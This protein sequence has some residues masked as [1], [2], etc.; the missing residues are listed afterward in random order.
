[1]A[2]ESQ[3]T[4][5]IEE[6]G[7][8]GL[9]QYREGENSVLFDWEFGS[10]SAVVLIWPRDSNEWEEIHPWAS[11]RKL[12]IMTNVGRDVCR[13]KA[14]SCSFEIDATNSSIMIVAK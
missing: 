7:R 2:S 10:D 6:M 3:W 4:V 14:P 9:I 8:C 1:M 12:E 5:A 13:Q 11:G